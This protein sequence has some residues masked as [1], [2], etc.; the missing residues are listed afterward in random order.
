MPMTRAPFTKKFP[1]KSEQPSAE[2]QQGASENT[3]ENFTQENSNIEGDNK[4]IENFEQKNLN[5]NSSDNNVNANNNLA[6]GEDKGGKKVKIF[7][8][9]NFFNFFI[10]K[11]MQKLA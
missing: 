7:N 10:E 8:K 4:I 1:N 5:L 11:K 3:G 6:K 9:I 2:N